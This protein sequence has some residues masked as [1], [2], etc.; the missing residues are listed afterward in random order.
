[1]PDGKAWVHA[2]IG[3]PELTDPLDALEGDITCKR[4]GLDP[5]TD[6]TLMPGGIL[7]SE[8]KAQRCAEYRVAYD[9]LRKLYL[10]DLEA[11]ALKETI[12][13]GELEACQKKLEVLAKQSELG[14]WQRNKGTVGFLIGA[15]VGVAL[16]V[17][18][19][20]A[21]GGR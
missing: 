9:E 11:C 19:L 20:Y 17:G 10:L 5:V 8:Q 4:V 21:V 7:M 3:P 15:V 13:T 2:T 14:W 18:V 6:Y 12:Y 1:M 16:A